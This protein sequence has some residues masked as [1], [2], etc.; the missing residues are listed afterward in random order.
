M[1][2]LIYNYEFV[3]MI[4]TWLPAEKI[5]R[6]LTHRHEFVDNTSAATLGIVTP[7]CTCLVIPM[8]IG[9][10]ESG[11]PLGVTFS[12]LVAS[13]MTNEVAMVLLWG[14]FGPRVAL[15][16]IAVGMIIAMMSGW[17]IG[18]LHLEKWVEDYV[19]KLKVGNRRFAAMSFP[20]RVRASW[21]YV[22]QIF[23]KVAPWVALRVGIGAF[24]DVYAPE[25]SLARHAGKNNPFAV[26][27]AVLIGIP[28]CS[29]AAVNINGLSPRPIQILD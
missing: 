17:I 3:A 21:S 8:L 12:F 15:M 10:V 25:N 1:L 9:F 13:R 11:V 14:L 6:V 29:N 23:H 7:L 18:R 26:L 24:I 27:L 5:K 22:R 16:Y 19:Y 28:L 4:R 2:T 20:D